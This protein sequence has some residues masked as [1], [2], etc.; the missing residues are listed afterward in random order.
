[1]LHL[2]ADPSVPP[3]QLPPRKPPIA[4]KANYKQG[5]DKVTKLGIIKP[6]V[7][8]TDWVSATVMMLKPNGKVRLYLDPKPQSLSFARKRRPLDSVSLQN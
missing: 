2:Q 6:V 8:P 5:L 4:F 3:V 1:M 7:E